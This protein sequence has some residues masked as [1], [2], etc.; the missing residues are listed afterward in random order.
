M[1]RRHDIGSIARPSLDGKQAEDI[2]GSLLS[3]K[4]EF[5][6]DWR[7]GELGVE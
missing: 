1:M 7:G 3:G 2:E 4:D 5:F 6:Q